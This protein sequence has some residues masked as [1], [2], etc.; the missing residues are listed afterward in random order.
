MSLDWLA[1]RWQMSD[2]FLRILCFLLDLLSFSLRATGA[3]RLSTAWRAGIA[4]GR[5]VAIGLTD[6]GGATKGAF[7]T[8]DNP[9]WRPPEAKQSHGIAIITRCASNERRAAC[10]GEMNQGNI[11][12]PSERF[13]ELCP[14]LR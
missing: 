11:I 5:R 13:I 6:C 10:Q 3:L 7:S 1:P 14:L 12:Y 2:H 9:S 8:S 4:F